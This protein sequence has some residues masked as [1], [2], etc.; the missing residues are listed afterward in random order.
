MSELYTSVRN[1][2][3]L[4][5]MQNKEPEN[6]LNI[7]W[8]IFF[9]TKNLSLLYIYNL[10][11][12]FCFCSLCKLDYN[13]MV[14]VWLTVLLWLHWNYFRTET[15][16]KLKWKVRTLISP[17]M[18]TSIWRL[19]SLVNEWLNVKC[20][21]PEESSSKIVFCSNSVIQVFLS[22]CETP[23]SLHIGESVVKKYMIMLWEESKKM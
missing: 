2:I 3:W 13:W 10:W 4:G 19:S 1:F 21:S 16:G 14:E 9:L 22:I 8:W 15:I 17:C 23:K 5:N 20:T 7:L 12:C 18:D 11:R 6:L